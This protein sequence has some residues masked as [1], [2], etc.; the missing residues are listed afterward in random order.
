MTSLAL[1]P[2]MITALVQSTFTLNCKGPAAEISNGG[3]SGTSKQ[4]VQVNGRNPVMKPERLRFAH[5]PPP[6][7]AFP[8]SAPL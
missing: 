7:P 1:A 8:I 2:A 5:A 3:L 4:P 6:T